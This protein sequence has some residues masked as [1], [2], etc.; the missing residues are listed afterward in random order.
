MLLRWQW[1]VIIALLIFLLLI[2]VYVIGYYLGQQS[3]ADCVNCHV[4]Y[5]D[6]ITH[7]VNITQ[8]ST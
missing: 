6:V 3:V 2:A 1:N 4:H 7:A 8:N 5:K